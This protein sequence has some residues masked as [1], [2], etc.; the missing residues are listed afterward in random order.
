MVSTVRSPA[1]HALPNG[2]ERAPLLMSNCT[3]LIVLKGYLKTA[4]RS[5]R[6]HPGYAALNVVGLAIG[7]ACCLLIGLYVRHE[8]AYDDFH[9]HADR[10]YRVTQTMPNEDAAG[11]G[12]ALG[13][14]LAEDFPQVEAAIRL[15]RNDKLVAVDYPATG[16]VRRFEEDVPEASH[17]S[18][19]LLTSFDTFKAEH[20][21]P[22]SEQYTSYWWPW[23]WTYVLLE[24]GADAEALQAQLGDFIERRRGNRAFAPFLQPI[25]RIHLHSNLLDE[26]EPNVSAAMVNVLGAITLFVLLLACVNYVNL[27]TARAADRLREVGVRKS[28]GAG[29]WQVARQFLSE[30]L[31]LT[32]AAV[33]VALAVAQL[34]LPFFNSL[35]GTDLSLSAGAPAF[36]TALGGLAL[37]VG[38]GAG[39]YTAFVLSRFEPAR[40]LKSSGRSGASRSGAGLRKGLVVFQFTVSIALI[41]ATAIAFQQLGYL[42]TADLGFDEARVAAVPLKATAPADP[43]QAALLRQ[44]AVEAVAFASQRPGFGAITE[45]PFEAEGDHSYSLPAP[46]DTDGEEPA[47]RTR[48]QNVSAGYFSTMQIPVLA[49]REFSEAH[50]A[51]LGE[52]NR[53]DQHASVFFRGR[54][55]I[56]N[57]AAVEA[58][59][60]TPEEALAKSF[61]LFSSEGGT[62]YLDTEGPVMGVVENIHHSSM[63][64][65]IIPMVYEPVD[66]PG[67]GTFGMNYALAKLAPG[68]A[69]AA[70]DALEAAW[71]EVAPDVPFNAS[72]LDQA[73]D[74]RYERERRLGQILAAFAVLAILIACL[75]LFGLAAYTAQ[76]RTKEIGICK[77]LGATATRIVGLLSKDFLRLVAV[78]VMLAMPLTYLG[79]QRW[80]NGF[81]YRIDL[82]PG[83]FLAA[84]AVALGIALLTVSYHALRAARTNPADALQTE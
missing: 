3:F 77:A 36:W 45:T 41:A 33:V 60:W 22:A 82:G 72:F 48:Y 5:L 81:A 15:I 19:D 29:R 16:V 8:L 30:A 59:G 78:A 47:R 32:G 7:L 75:A 31:L 80:L 55:K 49:G 27:A 76:Q 58:L 62:F 68:S 64:E 13:P 69:A 1:P 10:L 46:A 2:F 54:A 25:T 56:L 21:T 17:L 44:P 4:L 20:G 9:A 40:V 51:D 35:A 66:V 53:D 61:R 28:V 26:W 57:R 65:R 39:G 83:V 79:M 24:E 67:G 12:A 34:A 11:T 43:L 74:N 73:L 84:G 18:F 63:R 52:I 42:R 50:P 14:A 23:V 6:R 37:V 38:L 71:N 70:M